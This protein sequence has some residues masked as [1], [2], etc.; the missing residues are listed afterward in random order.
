MFQFYCFPVEDVSN[1]DKYVHMSL[2]T[3]LLIYLHSFHSFH[4]N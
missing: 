1:T 2:H 3:K 4:S